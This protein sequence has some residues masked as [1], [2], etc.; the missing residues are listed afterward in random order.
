M[1]LFRFNSLSLRIPLGN[2]PVYPPATEWA[3]VD[4]DAILG[5]LARE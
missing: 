5:K 4:D 1:M 3:V 2:V